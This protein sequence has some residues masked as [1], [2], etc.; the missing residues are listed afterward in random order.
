MF[1]SKKIKKL[2]FFIQSSLKTGILLIL[3]L[4]IWFFYA[5][6]P[7][8]NTKK[9]LT[10]TVKQGDSFN[11]I[12]RD[13]KR[14]GLIRSYYASKI[15]QTLKGASLKKGEYNLSPHLSAS[16]IINMLNRGQ[17]LT[18]FKITFPEGFIAQQI[19]DRL[20]R[21]GFSKASKDFMETIKDPTII[22]QYNIQATSLEGYLFPSTYYI[23]HN[24]T[25]HELVNMM[26]KAFFVALHK[27]D[28]NIDQSSLQKQVILAS[29]I[30]KE[31]VID[32]DRP[33]IASVFLN[34]LSNHMKLESCAT[35]IYIFKTKGIKKQR[36]YFKDLKIDSPFNTYTNF[37]LPPSPISNPGKQSLDAA[38]HPAQTPY[39]FFVYE[40]NGKHIFSRTYKEHLSYYKKYIRYQYMDKT[41]TQR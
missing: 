29:I 41:Q 12:L 14:D 22:K 39:L 30:E 20:E 4:L 25:A 3:I 13:L 26:V 23:P 18:L 31:A 40:G 5:I 9:P 11:R 38:F 6:R 2:P 10:Y 21:Q 35:V 8:N 33:L 36:V 37:G 24:I 1:F 7:I 34:R 19:R 27:I 28:A 15:L 17:Q 32:S 16:Q